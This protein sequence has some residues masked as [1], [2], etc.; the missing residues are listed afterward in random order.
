M[1]SQG[2]PLDWAWVDVAV[3]RTSGLPPGIDM[4]GF[5]SRSPAPMDV[6]MVAHP[7]VTLLLDLSMGDG[8]VYDT[9]GR[10]GRGS[11]V[12]G[13]LPGELRAVGGR[14]TSSSS[15]WSRPWRPRCSGRRPS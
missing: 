2:A 13:L 5:S 6:A 9:E 8:V 4:A 3:P 14:A 11:V 1:L 12:V 15:A 10:H 7:S